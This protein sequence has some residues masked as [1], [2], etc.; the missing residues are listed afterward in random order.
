MK[1]IWT[2]DD[3][4]ERTP[5]IIFLA[6]PTP[7][8]SETP[9]WRPE[10]IALLSELGFTGSVCIPEDPPNR[11]E[12]SPSFDSVAQIEWEER[13]L[14]MADVI[15]FWVPRELKKMPAFTTNIEWGRWHRSGKVV[16]GHP[17]GAPHTAY[18][19]YYAKKEGVPLTYD[20]R[21]TLWDAL[22]L[23]EVHHKRTLDAIR[24]MQPHRE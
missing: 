17:A 21:G 16:L 13:C 11:S 5:P 6:G 18:M 2:H 23:I 9:S 24:V 14:K 20:L 3:P 15:V 22:A 8:D 12:R 4:S 19:D 1:L 10:A 7:R